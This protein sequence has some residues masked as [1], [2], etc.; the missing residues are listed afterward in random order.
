MSKA[1]PLLAEVRQLIDAARQRVASA[2]DAELTQLHG[3]L[4]R[5]SRVGILHTLCSPS[6]PTHGAAAHPPARAV[7]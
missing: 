6:A 4:G 2:V 1:N 7:P 5:C 3:H